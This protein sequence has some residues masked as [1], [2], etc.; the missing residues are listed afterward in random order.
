MTGPK[1]DVGRDL[2]AFCAA[3]DA[4]SLSDVPGESY[5]ETAD[6]IRVIGG[7]SGG[8]IPVVPREDKFGTATAVPGIEQKRTAEASMEGYVMPSGSLDTVPDIGADLL[9]KGGWDLL[10]NS[11]AAQV[12]LGGASTSGRVDLGASGGFNVGDGVIVETGN[13]TGFFEARR[14]SGVDVGGTNITVEPPLT[15]TPVDSATVKGCI[16]YKPSDSRDNME[17]ALTLWLMNNNSADRISGWSP[18]SYDFTMGGEDAARYTVSGAGQRH[19]RFFQN[20]LASDLATG[21]NPMVVYLGNASAGDALGTYWTLSD[22]GGTTDEVVKITDI[23]G[24]TWTVDRGQLGSPM[25][26]GTWTAGATSITPYRPAGSYAGAPVPDTSGQI[27]LSGGGFSSGE[28]LSIQCNGAS[29]SCGFGVA[30]R[31]D[32]HGTMYKAQGYTMSQREVRATLSGWTLKEANMMAAV[33]AFQ[34]TATT[35]AGSQQTSVVVQSGQTAGSMFS[36]VAPRFRTE[37]VS[38]DRGAEE[39]TIELTGL[40]EGTSNGADEILLIFS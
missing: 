18:T 36:W 3:Q 16:S 29:L 17:D 37:D 11:G 8:T 10:N 40:C 22:G 25:N 32:V 23:S 1:I 12:V 2:V 5:P 7:S 6:A 15:F 9:L 21:V 31:E 30:L 28:S 13:G 4:Y 39:V 14:I 35:G 19:D 27:V 24:N 20:G 33:Q 26:A 34:T 38:L